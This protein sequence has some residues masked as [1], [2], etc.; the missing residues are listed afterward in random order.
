MP[1]CHRH[2]DTQVIT[3]YLGVA[4]CVRCEAEAKAAVER[5]CA[6]CAAPVSEPGLCP[7][8]Q[9][10][11]ARAKPFAWVTEHPLIVAFVIVLFGLWL[12]LPGLCR[13][14]LTAYYMGCKEGRCDPDVI[15]IWT[16]WCG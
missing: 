10:A 11:A 2:P 15:R 14:G 7:A 12:V 13:M 6:R 16:A 8:C 9:K 5:Q 1:F 4:T 3:D